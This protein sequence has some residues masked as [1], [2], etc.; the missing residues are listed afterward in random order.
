M[1][2]DKTG[3]GLGEVAL[4]PPPLFLP[5]L[6]LSLLALSCLLEV[7]HQAQGYEIDRRGHHVDALN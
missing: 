6:L 3:G 4:P 1:S 2:C 5:V 7:S